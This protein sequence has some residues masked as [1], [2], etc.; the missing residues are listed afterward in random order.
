MEKEKK[1]GETAVIAAL[2]TVPADAA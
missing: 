2:V 1:K